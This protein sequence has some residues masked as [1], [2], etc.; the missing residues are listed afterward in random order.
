MRPFGSAEDLERRRR[1]AV[2]L[3]R[4]G[5][6]PVEVAEQLGVDRR[7]VRRWRAA[8]EAGGKKALA[9]RPTPGRP[10]KLSE[11]ERARLEQVLLKGARAAGYPTDLWTCPRVAAV[12][13]KRFRVGYHVDH[14]GRLLRSMGWSP[15]KPV[16]RA[17]ERDEKAI[18][19]WVKETWPRVKKRA[20]DKKRRSSSSTRAAS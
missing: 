19:R 2:K 4:Q 11:R 18:R 20:R 6:A 16:R 14:V 7:S 8:F 3:L 1:E 17:R 5:M 13:K 10:C 9:A 15:Q 12:I